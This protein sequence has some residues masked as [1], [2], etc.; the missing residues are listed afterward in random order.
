MRWH[1][2]SWLTLS[3]T[4]F[5]I[6]ANGGEGNGGRVSLGERGKGKIMC[7]GFLMF[8]LEYFQNSQNPLTLVS[9]LSSYLVYCS[10]PAASFVP[11]RYPCHTKARILKSKL[12][13]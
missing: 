3:C 10:S 9:F 13:P 1:E 4:I 2:I 11:I 5:P 6:H 8:V 7:M 12:S